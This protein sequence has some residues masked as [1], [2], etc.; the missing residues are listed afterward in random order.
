MMQRLRNSLAGMLL[1][2]TGL[3]MGMVASAKRWVEPVMRYSEHSRVASEDECPPELEGVFLDEEESEAPEGNDDVGPCEEIV[4]L[5][6]LLQIEAP[7][8]H[9]LIE[10]PRATLDSGATN[11]VANA[12]LHFPGATVVPSDASRRG[13][14]YQG[15]GKETIP[16]RGEFT[17]RIMTQEGALA[18]TTWQDAEVRKPL[19]AVSACADKGNMTVFDQEGSCILSGSSPEINAILPNVEGSQGC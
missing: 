14:V 15:P 5:E 8:K 3:C 1:I 2:S 11:P 12:R 6:E 7:E 10:G 19:M 18:N 16:N 4:S 9:G 13:V 17:E